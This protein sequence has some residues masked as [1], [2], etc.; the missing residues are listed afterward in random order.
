MNLNKIFTTG[1]II[2]TMA[3]NS[4]PKNNQKNPGADY[5]SK[6]LGET[7][8]LLREKQNLT[9]TDLGALSHLSTAEISKLENGAR[10]KIPLDSLIRIAPHLNVSLDYLLCT[11]VNNYKSDFERYYDFDGNALDLE[12]LSQTIYS[13]DS[14]LLLMISSP[15][16]L[17]DYESIEFIKTWIKLKSKIDTISTENILK[18]LFEEFKDYCYKFVKSLLN[19]LTSNSSEKIRNIKTNLCQ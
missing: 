5:N 4:I 16:F 17:S 9:Q 12:K 7:I 3:H 1:G 6:I 8:R 11:C 14:E 13:V 15:S 19:N 2:L 10:K 18:N